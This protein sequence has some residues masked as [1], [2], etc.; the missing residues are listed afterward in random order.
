MNDIAPDYTVKELTEELRCSRSTVWRLLNKGEI[1]GYSIGTR[2]N[3]T[4]DS[5]DA[6]KERHRFRPV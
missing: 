3:I 6:Y 1:T 4:R 5:V 2:M